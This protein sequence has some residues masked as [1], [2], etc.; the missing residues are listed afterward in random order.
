M[1]GIAVALIGL[2]LVGPAPA[3]PSW[4]N[5]VLRVSVRSVPGV[6]STV[7]VEIRNTTQASLEVPILATFRLRPAVGAEE[8]RPSD[9][10]TLVSVFDPTSDTVA[11][12][13]E[14]D[15][16]LRLPARGIRRVRV[17][18]EKLKWSLS[19]PLYVWIPRPLSQVVDYPEYDLELEVMA[20]GMLWGFASSKPIRIRLSA[21]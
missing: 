3:P 11:D 12:A 17:D 5:P 6:R 13:P 16:Q 14:G 20:H 18:L 15:V 19:P 4:R 8:S 10:S 9:S 21:R 1:D 2:A 7:D